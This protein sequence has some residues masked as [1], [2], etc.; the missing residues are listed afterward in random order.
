MA[1]IESGVM[2]KLYFFKGEQPAHQNTFQLNS[3]GINYTLS[4]HKN[5]LK[6][7]KFSLEYKSFKF[8]THV[9]NGNSDDD[10]DMRESFSKD[11]KPA[12]AEVAWAF[13]Y[14]LAD[15]QVYRFH[16]IRKSIFEN[17]SNS[18]LPD[19][20]LSRDGSNIA[21]FL[22]HLKLKH[23]F[24]YEKILNRVSMD[25]PFIEDFILVPIPWGDSKGMQLNW[26][27]K[28][29]KHVFHPCQLSDGT[30]RLICLAA[31]LLQPDPPLAVVIDEPELGLHP[32][33]VRLL[34][35]SI[36]DAADKTQVII[37][38]HSP[39]LVDRFDPKDII[40]VNRRDGASHLDRFTS[41]ELKPWIEEY[42]LGELWVKNHLR[43]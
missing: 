4:M 25:S 5:Q 39:L 3:A 15:L 42:T 2:T 1:I 14:L 17:P 21:N 36:R 33:A 10:I 7:A 20:K 31:A 23:K 19:T 22:L 35:E 27:Q 9:V 13:L 43:R 37:A 38:T 8:G 24:Y 30:L 40:V 12:D 18:I 11:V 41:N 28:N 29:V 26:K 34:A 32:D 6:D 16:H